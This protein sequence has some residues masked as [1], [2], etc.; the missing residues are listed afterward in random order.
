MQTIDN[1]FQDA[2]EEICTRFRGSINW[3]L[4]R[5]NRAIAARNRF[6]AEHGEWLDLDWSPMALERA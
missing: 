3:E 6:L 4:V 5:R 1:V 2:I